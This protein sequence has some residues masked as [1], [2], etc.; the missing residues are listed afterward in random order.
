MKKVK[1]LTLEDLKAIDGGESDAARK[2]WRSEIGR[3]G[4]ARCDAYGLAKPGGGDDAGECSGENGSDS[5]TISPKKSG[6]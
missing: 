5:T 3:R 4:K 2:R 1:K 6:K